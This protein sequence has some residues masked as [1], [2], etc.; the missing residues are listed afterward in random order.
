MRIPR[1]NLDEVE[2]LVIAIKKNFVSAFDISGGKQE[3]F[4]LKRLSLRYIC[5][6]N[7]GV[8]ESSL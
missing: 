8:K 2:N 3:V 5:V 1:S 4:L 6:R 7:V